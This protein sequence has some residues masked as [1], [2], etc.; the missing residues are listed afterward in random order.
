[1]VDLVSDAGFDFA[2]RT[3]RAVPK[4]KL[5]AEFMEPLEEED[6]SPVAFTLDE[7][8][9]ALAFLMEQGMVVVDGDQVL[10]P[11]VTHSPSPLSFVKENLG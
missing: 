6:G 10:I 9:A 5:F 11:P 8:T 2:T 7:A 4:D 1:M 3:F